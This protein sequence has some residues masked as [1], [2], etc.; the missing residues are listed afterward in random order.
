M[1]RSGLSVTGAAMVWAFLAC[2]PGSPGP[3]RGAEAAGTEAGAPVPAPADGIEGVDWRWVGIVTPVEVIRPRPEG[4]ER[5]T[6]RLE[7]GTASGLADC[8]WF[9]GSYTLE[10]KAL[11]FGPLAMTRMACPPGSLG[12]RYAGYLA[13]VRIMFTQDDTLYMDMMADGGTLRFVRD[14]ATAP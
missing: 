5:Y 1:N 10:D 7:A 2:S 4:P 11:T 3:E 8:N 6:L 14:G 13:Y 12:E 9:S